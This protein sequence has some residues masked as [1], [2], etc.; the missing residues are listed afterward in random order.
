MPKAISIGVFPP[1]TLCLPS[2][3]DIDSP[4]PPPPPQFA[5]RSIFKYWN[6]VWNIL[7][8]IRLRVQPPLPHLQPLIRM[9]QRAIVARTPFAYS[10]AIHLFNNMERAIEVRLLRQCDIVMCDM[11]MCDPMVGDARQVS[12]HAIGARQCS[13]HRLLYFS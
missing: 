2:L 8:I 9:V 5:H 1:A 12:S 4:T 11:V 3:R 7:G 13:A 6:I 10:L